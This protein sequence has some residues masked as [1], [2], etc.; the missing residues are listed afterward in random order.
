[1]SSGTGSPSSAGLAVRRGSSFF[2]KKNQ[3]KFSKFFCLHCVS[4]P[5]EFLWPP[6]AR[7]FGLA[8][9]KLPKISLKPK[10]E[11]YL[12]FEVGFVQRAAEAPIKL[13]LE[14][15]VSDVERSEAEIQI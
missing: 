13:D 4:I 11:F 12:I 5:S 1:M 15:L 14:V 10:S 9:A 8:L 3:N 6:E 2:S 7:S